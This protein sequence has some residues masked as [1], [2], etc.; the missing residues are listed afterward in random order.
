MNKSESYQNCG[1]E[2]LMNYVKSIAEIE[3][4]ISYEDAPK[5]ILPRNKSESYRN[6]GLEE[7]INYV[8]SIA[9]IETDISY[10]DAPKQI[11]PVQSKLIEVEV[12]AITTETPQQAKGEIIIGENEKFVSLSNLTNLVALIEGLQLS[13]GNLVKQVTYLSSAIAEFHQD[14]ESYKAQFQQAK[15]KLKEKEQELIANYQTIEKLTCELAIANQLVAQVQA[16]Y[17]EQSYQLSAEKDNCRDLRTRLNREQQHSFQLKVALEKCLEVPS[18]SYQLA[19]EMDSKADNADDVSSFAAKA[20]PI[21]PWTTQT[22]S[23]GNQIDLDW[24]R[25]HLPDQNKPMASP[26]YVQPF[27]GLR[28]EDKLIDAIALTDIDEVQV[29]SPIETNGAS[30]HKSPSPL[31]YPSRP[32]KGRKS[33]AAIE[34]PSFNS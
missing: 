2:E 24:E 20:P 28:T 30:M 9:E 10:E 6:C 26:E 27:S 8:K 33:L 29:A 1:L 16:D 12:T 5:Q 19:D 23:G 32:P 18:A 4:N 17:N 3:A 14:L 25:Q 15:S 11:L 34:L 22:R 21:K 31:V 13:N 7:L